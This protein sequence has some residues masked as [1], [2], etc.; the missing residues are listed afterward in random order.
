MRAH[1]SMIDAVSVPPAISHHPP[2]FNGGVRSRPSC[3]G[4]GSSASHGSCL[5]NWIGSQLTDASMFRPITTNEMVPSRIDA[6][7]RLPR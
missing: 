5:M 4:G 2:W 3:G 6:S 7:P 1:H